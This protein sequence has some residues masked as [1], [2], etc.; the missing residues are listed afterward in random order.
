MVCASGEEVRPGRACRDQPATAR[1]EDR[2]DD[3]GAD[4][5]QAEHHQAGD[6]PPHQALLLATRSAS[7]IDSR[8][9]IG[10][11]LNSSICSR[12]AKIAS[13]RRRWPS[14]VE[15]RV[16]S[17]TSPRCL[18][19]DQWSARAGGQG[20]RVAV[21]RREV[22]QATVDD[23]EVAALGAGL[24]GLLQGG[25]CGGVLAG[26]AAP[27]DD[28]VGRVEVGLLACVE[29]GGDGLGLLL[30]GLVQ[31][32]GGRHAGAQRRQPDRQ[33]DDL[34]ATVAGRL[35]A[36]QG[37][38]A[39]DVSLT[40]AG[41]VRRERDVDAVVTDEI[42]GHLLGR[43]SGQPDQPAAGTDRRQHVLDGRGAEHPHG[44][45]GRLL[46]R[47]EQGVESLVGEPV[48]VLDD[49]H[50]EARAHRR[51]RRAADQLAHLVDS[52]GQLVGARPG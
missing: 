16:S 52:D 46:D 18:L 29:V 10:G 37:P 30:G 32:G 45:T 3:A 22:H 17:A 7:I 24:L 51:Q 33:R 5:D 31:V 21:D 48:G 26:P 9:S 43:R 1:H 25:Q 8:A 28:A 34:A 38:S 4:G 19:V 50:L 15:T 36:G 41:G 13:I 2:A 39:P 40:G 49:E 23:V 47:L 27:L 20:D 11:T 44:V 12:A 35:V 14:G 6:P 42:G